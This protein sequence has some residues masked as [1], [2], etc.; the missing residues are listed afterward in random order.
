MRRQVNQRNCNFQFERRPVSVP[1]RRADVRPSRR[2][3][4]DGT[5][6]SRARAGPGPSPVMVIRRDP[7]PRDTCRH[8]PRRARGLPEGPLQGRAVSGFTVTSPGRTGL[9]GPARVI[10]VPTAAARDFSAILTVSLS[11]CPNSILNSCATGLAWCRRV[12]PAVTGTR[13]L[14]VAARRRKR[15]WRRS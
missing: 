6:R 7:V 13:G 11:T 3:F 10:R 8:G 15:Q 9:S 4:P 14:P 5:S 12:C 1:R 2:A